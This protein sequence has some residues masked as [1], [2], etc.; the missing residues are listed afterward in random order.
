MIAGE[1]VTLYFFLI[2]TFSYNLAGALSGGLVSFP[3]PRN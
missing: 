2:K 1:V 3:G